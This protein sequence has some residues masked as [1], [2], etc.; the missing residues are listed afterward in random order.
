MGEPKGQSDT[1]EQLH[2]LR[3]T[4]DEL[5]GEIG[6]RLDDLIYKNFMALDLEADF[7]APFRERPPC[8]GVRYI[9]IG[10]VID[11]GAMF[12]AYTG[13]PAVAART[14]QAIAGI[15]ATRDPDGYIGHMPK[16]ADGSQNYRNWVLHDQEYLLLGLVHNYTYRGGGSS[17]QYARELADYILATAPNAPKLEMVCTAGLPEAMLTLYECTGERR[18]LRFAAE[19]RHGYST[20]E[21]ECASLRDWHQTYERREVSHVYVNL[22]RCCAQLMLHRHEPDE[23]LLAMSRHVMHELVGN[24]PGGLLITGSTSDDEHFS[25][26]Q[27]GAGKIGESCVTAYLIRWL[28]LLMRLEGDLGYGDWI[29]RA[30]YNGL[31]A[32]QGPTGRRLRYFTPFTGERAYFDRDG[33]CCPGNYRRIVAELP[34]MVYYRTTD[35]LAV[36]LYTPSQTTIDLSDDV[37][38]TIA[39]QTDYPNSGLV[40]IPVTASEPREFPLRLR[41]P[42]WCP[43]ATVAVNGEQATPVT[44]RNGAHEIRRVWAP[45]DRVVLDMPMA[46]R[47]VRGR[48]IQEGR[49]AL[50]RGPVLYCIGTREDADIAPD[51]NTARDF[52]V[53]STSLRDPGPDVEMRPEGLKAVAMA[54][55]GSGSATEVTFTEFI[56]PT[57]IATYFR[58]PHDAPT[59]PDELLS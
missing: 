3:L 30:I 53:D 56:D 40:E 7:V 28:D 8:E 26:D 22:A 31:F 33:Y 37:S 19:H 48:G 55:T 21:I 12:A 36:S 43:N 14:D 42:R 35:G 13:D 16:E 17:L 27:N 38:V 25:R 1:V 29:E 46:W 5:G 24:D 15:M 54:R 9:G 44:A 6:R 32:A 34:Q 4:S 2:P 11:A 18:Y 47:L 50:M 52:V 49:A 23:R 39:Q 45:G 41:I 58:V 51:A 20:S 59:L 10:K 57:G